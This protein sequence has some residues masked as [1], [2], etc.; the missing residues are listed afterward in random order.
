MCIPMGG[1]R[2][3]ME[4]G[5]GGEIIYKDPQREKYSFFVFTD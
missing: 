5:D 2:N 1:R 4:G 3:R